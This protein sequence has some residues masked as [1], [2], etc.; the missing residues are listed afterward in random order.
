MAQVKSQQGIGDI[1]P[2]TPGLGVCCGSPEALEP[3]E[4][5]GQLAQDSG[6]TRPCT[7]TLA[8]PT[9]RLPV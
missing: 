9:P 2:V 6:L 7:E 1:S 8:R 4:W 3:Q 5:P